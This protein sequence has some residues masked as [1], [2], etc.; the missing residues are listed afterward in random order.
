MKETDVLQAL[1]GLSVGRHRP[2]EDGRV[3]DVAIEW[4]GETAYIGVHVDDVW[5][6]EAPPDEV[7]SVMRERVL[8]MPGVGA[9]RI[10]P[11]SAERA[12]QAQEIA[13]KN[14]QARR[15]PKLPEGMQILAVQSGKGGVGKSTVSVNL[16]VAIG[17]LGVATALLDCDIYGFSVPTLLGIDRLPQVQ[18]GR[19]VPPRAYGVEVMSMDFFVRENQ[20]VMWRGPMLGKALHQ[21]TEETAW[22]DPKVMVLDL[23]PGTGDVALDV[24]SFFPA[25]RVIVVTTPD[26]AA[27][28]VAVR[29]G[30]M[31]KTVGHS[32]IGVVEN[33]AYA[34]CESCGHKKEYWGKGGGEIVARALGIPVLARIAW[35]ESLVG[36]E[37]A[38]ASPES[39]AAHAYADLAERALEAL[40]EPTTPETGLP[41]EPAGHKA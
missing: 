13:K 4:H 25:A 38:V 30:K 35:C 17:R 11:R 28:R 27:A 26:P 6:G 15:E 12:R 16:A 7:M 5:E 22:S 31:A 23:P 10:I 33:L 19:L 14:R 36:S 29:A 20:A 34:T 3:Q 32:L 9:A 37:V 39:D 21:M 41:K 40:S 18:D 24:H 1:A 2:L 8:A